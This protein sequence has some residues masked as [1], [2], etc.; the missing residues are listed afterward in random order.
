[1]SVRNCYVQSAHLLLLVALGTAW[2]TNPAYL[3]T[4]IAGQAGLSSSLPR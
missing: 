4:E 3:L 2:L 1:M